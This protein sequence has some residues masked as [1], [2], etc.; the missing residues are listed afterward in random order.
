MGNRLCLNVRGMVQPEAFDD[1]G[2]HPLEFAG[3]IARP[4]SRGSVMVL[5]G[6]AG[7]GLTDFEMT[8]LRD[9]RA[10]RVAHV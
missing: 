7:S 1:G 2:K 3:Q 8:E 5:A 10:A 4:G 6:S 9:M